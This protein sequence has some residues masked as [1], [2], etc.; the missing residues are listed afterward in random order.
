[1]TMQPWPAIFG[2][3]SFETVPPADIRQISVPLKSKFSSAL[4]FKNLVAERDLR[5]DRAGRGKRHD[6]SGRKPAL[7][8]NIEHFAPDV[9]GRAN[10]GKLEIHLLLRPQIGLYFGE[11]PAA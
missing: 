1:M 5:A 9:S 6:L 10:N 11:H 8:E 7:G 2:A 3:H 4:H